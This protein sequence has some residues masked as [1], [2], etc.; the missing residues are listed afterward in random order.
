MDE[1]KNLLILAI[2]AIVAI[3]AMVFGYAVMN[4]SQANQLIASSGQNPQSQQLTD[5]QF[6]EQG[7]AVPASGDMAGNGVLLSD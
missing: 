5:F 6:D 2:V 7:N 4:N 3:V 1:N